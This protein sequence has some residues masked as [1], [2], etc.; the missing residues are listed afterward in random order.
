[1]TVMMRGKYTFTPEQTEAV[2]QVFDK[3]QVLHERK[4]NL[5][6]KEGCVHCMQWYPLKYEICHE[7][8]DWA[9]ERYCDDP[10]Q[11]SRVLFDKQTEESEACFQQV[12]MSDHMK[13]LLRSR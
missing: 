13:M 8:H 4:F 5:K 2:K 10:I 12:G 1:V 3:C 7:L 6:R 9:C 11:E